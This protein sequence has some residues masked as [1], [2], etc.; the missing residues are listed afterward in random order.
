MCVLDISLCE[1]VLERAIFWLLVFVIVIYINV[2]LV[3]IHTLCVSKASFGNKMTGMLNR[4]SVTLW[5]REVVKCLLIALLA[6]V[7]NSFS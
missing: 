3:E 1:C 7:I 4:N 2:A 5:I 6:T